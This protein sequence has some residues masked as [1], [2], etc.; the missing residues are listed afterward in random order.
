MEVMGYSKVRKQ[1][2]L[3]QGASR[4]PI[5]NPKILHHEGTKG[6]KNFHD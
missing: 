2:S 4:A 1:R 3:P 6:T 5:K